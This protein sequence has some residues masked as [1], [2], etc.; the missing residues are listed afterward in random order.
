MI[1]PVR[2]G[3]R[4]GS[5]LRR[6]HQQRT[7]RPSRSGSCMPCPAAKSRRRRPQVIGS[8]G[9]ILAREYGSTWSDSPAKKVVSA[10]AFAGTVVGQLAFGYLADGWSRTGS[11][12]VS[13]NILI[14]FTALAAASYYY[15]DAVGMFNM[16][17]AW[18]FFVRG[19]GW[20]ER[21]PSTRC[22]L[23]DSSRWA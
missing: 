5:F 9:A 11:L 10:I 21:T 20:R 19:Q 4:G 14:I 3:V 8:V 12:L 22:P 7:S 2:S 18:R 1:T 6:I 13:T 17:A 23:A 16:L 15:G